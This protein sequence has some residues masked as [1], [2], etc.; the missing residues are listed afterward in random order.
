MARIKSDR[1]IEAAAAI[2]QVDLGT[3]IRSAIEKFLVLKDLGVSTN[4]PQTLTAQDVLNSCNRLFGVNGR[5]PYNWYDPLTDK[6][7]KWQHNGGWPVGTVWTQILRLSAT[8]MIVSASPALAGESQVRFQPDYLGHINAEMAG[9]TL[10]A[11]DAA[12][13]FMRD[14]HDLES[15]VFADD[16]F[17]QLTTAFNLSEKEVGV[18]FGE[19]AGHFEVE[20]DSDPDVPMLATLLPK[21][22]E[23]PAPPQTP[24]PVPDEGVED[25]DYEWTSEYSLMP[26]PDVDVRALVEKVLELV[27]QA[28]LVLPDPDGLIERCVVS[29][30]TGHLILQGPPGTGKTTLARLLA[31]AFGAVCD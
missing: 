27:D 17:D 3:R 12:V 7:S 16:L 23:L 14:R 30:L 28:N 25:E 6:W 10:P 2:A 29:L 31:R 26:L 1:I 13:W 5:T 9:H 24:A 11:I 21:E 22:D 4:A 15:P 20:T 19:P 8:L 18:L